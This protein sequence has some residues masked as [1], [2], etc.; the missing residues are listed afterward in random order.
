[1]VAIV[2]NGEPFEPEVEEQMFNTE[3][4]DDWVPEDGQIVSNLTFEEVKQKVRAG[5]MSD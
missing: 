2:C 1:M 4:Y 5:Y 3:F